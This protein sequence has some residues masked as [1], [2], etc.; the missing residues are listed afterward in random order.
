MPTRHLEE[1]F[2][3]AILDT[4]ASRTIIGSDRVPHL[5]KALRGV[6]VRRGPR[7]VFSDLEMADCSIVKKPCSSRDM[8]KDGSALRSCPEAHHFYYRMQL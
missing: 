2:D 4:G 7:N 3:E 6:E 8:E 1:D 5:L